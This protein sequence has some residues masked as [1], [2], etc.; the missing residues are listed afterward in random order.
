M[1]DIDQLNTWQGVKVSK[2]IPVIAKIINATF[3]DYRGRKIKIRAW[4]GPRK[5][6]SW[7]DGG[8]RDYFALVSISTGQVAQMESNHPFYEANKNLN[9]MFDLPP[10]CLLVQHSIF[11]GKDIGITIFCRVADA[12]A[13][14]LSDS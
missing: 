13:I 11:A 5:L 7:W 9:G 10:L 4:K 2:T 6:D 1:I 12:S 14:R 8:S 3:P